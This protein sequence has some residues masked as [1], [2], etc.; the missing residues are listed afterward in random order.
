MGFCAIAWILILFNAGATGHATHDVHSTHMHTGTAPVDL[1]SGLWSWLIM[2]VA[3]MFPMLA[4]QIRFTAAASLWKRRHRAILGFLVG[5]LCSWLAFGIVASLL[6]SVFVQG[7]NLPNALAAAGFAAAM[8]WQLTP[9]K[10]R[11][12]LACHRR[13]P[14][15]PK[16]WRADRDCWRYGWMI[17]R[18][19]LVSCGFL[20]LACML[21]GHSLPAMACATAVGFVERTKQRPNQRLLCG[22]IGLL[23][24]SYGL[25]VFIGTLQLDTTLR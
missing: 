9:L 19:C 3:M 7:H 24:V 20:M 21:C 17:G 5:Y 22:A 25:L 12:L 23:A 14:I 1:M 18:S 8:L 11:S 15:S 16:G 13:L 10:K 4:K 2:V 6:G